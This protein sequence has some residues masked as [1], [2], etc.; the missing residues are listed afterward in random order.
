M[1]GETP[2]VLVFFGICVGSLTSLVGGAAPSGRLRGDCEVG[3]IAVNVD[4][5]RRFLWSVIKKRL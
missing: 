2:P 1:P 3:P 5:C 4:C